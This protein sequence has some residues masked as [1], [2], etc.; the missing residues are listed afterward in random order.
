MR[1]L[2][3]MLFLSQ[4]VPMLLHGDEV[5]RT[6]RGNN[7][8][9]CQDNEVSWLS[10]EH[11]PWQGQLLD[12]TKRLVKLRREHV[13]LRRRDYFL[14]AA[15]RGT[16]VKDIY[17]LQPDGTEMTDAAWR[18]ADVHT[19]AVMLPGAAVDLL[20]DGGNRIV[21]DTLLMLINASD[22]ESRFV[23]PATAGRRHWEMALDSSKPNANPASESYPSGGEYDLAPH[24]LALLINPRDPSRI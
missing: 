24:S 13:L 23:L 3:A 18:N 21:D 4:G 22:R 9:Y 12:W 5:G 1:N 8:P 2:L 10:W 11:E 7:N 14:G 6:Q 19:I 17:W 16:E 15:A 20:D